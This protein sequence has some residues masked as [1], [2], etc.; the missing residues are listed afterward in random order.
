MILAD[1]WAFLSNPA[2]LGIVMG[3]LIPIV[4]ILGGIWHATEKAKSTNALKRAMVKRGMSA[5]EIERVMAAGPGHDRE[6][7]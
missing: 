1:L 5:E 4:A 2:V 7:E 6:D 3:C